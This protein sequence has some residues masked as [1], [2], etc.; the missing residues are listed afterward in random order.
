[1]LVQNTSVVTMLA[2]IESLCAPL[3]ADLIATGRHAHH[4]FT[5]SRRL[6]ERDA[7]TGAIALLA[8]TP[9]SLA[10]HLGAGVPPA[11]VDF[12][13]ALLQPNPAQRPTAAEALEHPWLA[14]AL[15]VVVRTPGLPPTPWIA[16][17][18]PARSP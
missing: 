4:Y 5:R 14:G 2:R 3:P 1:M 13:E 7:A 6:Y 10:A 17:G 15:P 18:S 11:C 9:A 8:V 16:P 12:L